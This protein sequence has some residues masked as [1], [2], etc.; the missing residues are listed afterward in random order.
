MSK[1]KEQALEEEVISPEAEAEAESK[2]SQ[3]ET[4]EDKEQIRDTA[5]QTQEPDKDNEEL[6][7]QYMR[8][9]ADFQNY[10]RRTEKEKSDIYAFAN[11]KIVVELLDVID[12]FD[13]SLAMEADCK[14]EKMLEGMKLIFKQLKDVLEKNHVK[15]IEAAEADFDPNFHHAVMTDNSGEFES[16]RIT[17][18][19]QKGYTLNDKVVRPAM[20]KVA[21]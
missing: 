18:V 7:T 2:D 3:T 13:R 9:A 17:E 5:E 14:D 4:G 21:Q 11:E 12:N 15:E 1:E 6:Q 8:L 10:K 19:F 20:V 16:G